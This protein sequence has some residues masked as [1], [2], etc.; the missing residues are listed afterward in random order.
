[1]LF[2][3]L[4]ITFSDH[5]CEHMRMSN[6]SRHINGQVIVLTTVTE[7]Q[8]MHECVCTCQRFPE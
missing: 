3:F 4:V 1:M 5:A 2:C 6:N 8:K 7:R